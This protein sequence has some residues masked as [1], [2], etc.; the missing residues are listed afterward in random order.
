MLL[1]TKA[2]E[3]KVSTIIQI[4]IAILELKE[5]RIDCPNPYAPSSIY[6]TIKG[7]KN[8]AFKTEELSKKKK[9]KKLTIINPNMAKIFL[10]L[11]LIE[12]VSPNTENI[13]KTIKVAGNI[14]STLTVLVQCI[15]LVYGWKAK[16]GNAQKA[17]K[18]KAIINTFNK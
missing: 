5:K 10:S 16:K 6:P 3:A 2:I 1:L 11:F 7:G 4:D 14:S 9:I 13:W 12:Y 15:M 8:L 18:Q 17:V